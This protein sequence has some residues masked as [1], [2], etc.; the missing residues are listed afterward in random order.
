MEYGDERD[1]KV[2]AY[3]ESIAPMNHNGD[4]ISRPAF[5]MLLLVATLGGLLL[6]MGYHSR[7]QALFYYFRIED[8]VPE[9]HLLRLIDRYVSFQVN[10]RQARCI[11]NSFSNFLSRGES[12]LRCTK[13]PA[14]TGTG[15][16]R[17]GACSSARQGVHYRSGCDLSNQGQSG[18]GTRLLRQLADRQ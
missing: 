8:Q 3:L 4:V 18:G 12:E 10:Q 7:S 13:V 15:E 16:R 6:M 11:R 5:V 14:G 9:N 1:P 2:R 17:W